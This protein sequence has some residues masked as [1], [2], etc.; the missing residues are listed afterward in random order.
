MLHSN[1]I[2][3]MDTHV[4]FPDAPCN[5]RIPTADFAAMLFLFLI[6]LHFV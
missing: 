6:K 1:P 2:C 3:D 5:G 4:E